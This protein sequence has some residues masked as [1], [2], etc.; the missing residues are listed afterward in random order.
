MST[1]GFTGRYIE[2]QGVSATFLY[3]MEDVHV[4]P[5]QSCRRRRRRRVGESDPLWRGSRKTFDL[6]KDEVYTRVRLRTRV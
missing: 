2:A 6:I 1:I 5:L 3:P 4:S